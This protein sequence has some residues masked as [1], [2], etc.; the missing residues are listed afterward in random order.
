[1]VILSGMAVFHCVKLGPNSFSLLEY[2]RAKV[3]F[4]FSV[5]KGVEGEVDVVVVVV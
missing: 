5:V 1:V 2:V 3:C 4:S